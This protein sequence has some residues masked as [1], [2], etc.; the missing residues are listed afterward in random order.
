MKLVILRSPPTCYF[1][2]PQRKNYCNANRCRTYLPHASPV[3]V[4]LSSRVQQLP[5]CDIHARSSLSST[6]PWPAVL[7]H[8]QVLIP[9]E[10]RKVSLTPHNHSR[11]HRLRSPSVITTNPMSPTT[12]P[13]TQNPVHLRLAYNTFF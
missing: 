7:W 13:S 8:R 1:K 9:D 11:S 4:P 3:S 12:P 6:H 5:P 2:C 10:V